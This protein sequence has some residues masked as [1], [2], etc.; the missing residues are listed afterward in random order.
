MRVF[1]YNEEN[2]WLWEKKAEPSAVSEWR[3]AQ[4]EIGEYELKIFVSCLS[5][6]FLKDRNVCK[7]DM[8]RYFL[9]M[10]IEWFVY[11][12]AKY[13]KDGDLMIAIL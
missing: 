13:M 11:K 2:S 6:L 5:Y 4:F 3:R 1:L 10:V 12:V 7:T 8:F 9:V